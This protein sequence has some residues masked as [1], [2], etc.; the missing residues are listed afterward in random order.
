MKFEWVTGPPAE[1]VLRALEH[2]VAAGMIGEDGRLTASG[3]KVAECPV[4]V[5]VAR[6]V[7]CYRLIITS[8]T[9]FP[10]IA[11]QLKGLQVWRRDPYDRGHGG[12]PGNHFTEALFRHLHLAGYLHN[13]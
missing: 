1:S 12:C 4:E 8:R 5:S 11:F 3:E 7:V 13:T 6:M 2:L 9:N 10:F